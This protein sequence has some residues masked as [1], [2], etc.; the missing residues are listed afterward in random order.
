MV[1]EVVMVEE[2]VILGLKKRSGKGREKFDC[3]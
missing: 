2:M 1:K 3:R